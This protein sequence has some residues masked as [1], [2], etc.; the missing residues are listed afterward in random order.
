MNVTTRSMILAGLVTLLSACQ[1]DTSPR[2]SPTPTPTPSPGPKPTPDL[3]GIYDSF[4]KAQALPTWSEYALQAKL[5]G[6]DGDVPDP[7]GKP[8]TEDAGDGTYA[9]S[10]EPRSITTTPRDLVVLDPGQSSLWVGGLLQ[11]RGYASYGELQEFPVRKRA[12]FKV[13]INL[14]DQGIYETVDS[15]D[16]AT[17]Q[18]A[19]GKLVAKAIGRGTKV[20][21]KLDG[22]KS[23][24][25]DVKSALLKLG[26]SARYG[27]FKANASLA[28]EKQSH[29]N[30]V[31]VYVVENM[32]TVSMV[33]P[34]TTDDF[35]VGLTKAD[36]DAQL[37]AGNLGKDNL[38][39]YTAS[40]TYGRIVMLTFTSIENM[41]RLQFAV[42]AAYNA[43][44]NNA[45]LELSGEVKRTLKNTKIEVTTFG[46]DNAYAQKL[47]LSGDLNE[48]FNNQPALSQY[49]PI[50][51]T[52]KDMATDQVVAVS[53]TTKYN[54]RKC[55]QKHD[56]QPLPALK[57]KCET[58]G[59][60]W[61][62]ERKS[63]NSGEVPYTAPPR[64]YIDEA[65]TKANVTGSRGS[66]NYC[67]VTFSNRAEFP[68][69]G[70]Q[71]QTVS[72]HAHARSPSGRSSGSG[73]TECT[74]AGIQIRP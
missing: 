31:S 36:L 35:F 24:V 27:N 60:S 45:K 64:Y 21:G 68:G 38:P 18:E 14:L 71:P 63:C 47:M 30:R 51:Y 17:V 34:P 54:L 33:R 37:A 41:D 48:Y 29:E 5:V 57:A 58:S 1:Q 12:P 55:A 50:S 26:L 70:S 8:S 40:V 65:R 22:S 61:T 42:S 10:V 72:F 74:L 25:N 46:G 32:F 6:T 62:G 69:V 39:I 20:G 49:K 59:T 7:E 73:Y 66:D 13:W 16:P 3:T 53:E 56:E 19:V 23:E 2:P 44:V 9:C 28:T 43:V 15:P 52:M 4:V 67:V 11:G